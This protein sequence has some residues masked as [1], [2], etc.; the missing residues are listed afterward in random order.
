VLQQQQAKTGWLHGAA[1]EHTTLG[2]SVP[3]SCAHVP[4][5]RYEQVFVAGL[6]HAPFIW[7]EHTPGT[8]ALGP[9]HVPSLPMQS[10]LVD[11]MHAALR[12]QAP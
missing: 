10:Q 6:Q 8:Q 2:V 4:L 7:P 1:P 5:S 3:P 11:V 9:D 12:Q